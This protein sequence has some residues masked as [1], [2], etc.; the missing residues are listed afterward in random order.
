M[1]EVPFVSEEF[2]RAYRNTFRGQVSTGR[3]LHV[4]DTI[5][6]V[7]DFTPTA[8]GTS[9]PPELQYCRNNNSSV[10]STSVSGTGT[11]LAANAGF[12][13]LDVFLSVKDDNTRVT[14]YND[15]TV[16]QYTIY[17]GVLVLDAGVHDTLFESF[18]VYTPSSFSLKADYVP[19]GTAAGALNIV[20]TNIADVNGN[21][22]VPSGYDPQ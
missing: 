13:K 11:V 16:T 5:I 20:T 2:Q 19:S 18:V 9:L 21:L 17:N 4:S 6:P 3:D 22:V 10:F 12:Y 1:A 14:I 7:V 8:S 15:D